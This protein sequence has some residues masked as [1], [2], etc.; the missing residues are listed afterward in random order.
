MIAKKGVMLNL[1]SVIIN[2]KRTGKSGGSTELR[3]TTTIMVTFTPEQLK[4]QQHHSDLYFV[5][6]KN[7]NMRNA[8]DFILI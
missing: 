1:N 2:H 7:P 6:T 4:N 5:H 8:R 3:K